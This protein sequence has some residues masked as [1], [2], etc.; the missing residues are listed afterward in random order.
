M[1]AGEHVIFISHTTDDQAIAAAIRNLFDSVFENRVVTHYSNAREGEGGVPAG[2]DW[3]NWIAEQ[4]HQCD[5]ALVILS[6]ASL[7]KPWVLWEAGAVYGSARAAGDERRVVPLS[8]R[9]RKDNL[10]GPFAHIETKNGESKEEIDA[11]VSDLILKFVENKGMRSAHRRLDAALDGYTEAVAK[12]LRSAPILLTEP[13]IADWLRRIDGAD[14]ADIPT[15]EQWVEI[16]FGRTGRHRDRM[17]DVR[18][19]RRLGELYLAQKEY[20]SAV[21]QLGLA[22][23]ASPRDLFVLRRLGHALLELADR[24]T[25]ASRDQRLAEVEALIRDIKGFDPDAMK[26]NVECAALEARYHRSTDDW[27][28]AR[29]ILESAR[30]NNRS[31]NYLSALLAQ[32]YL[33][34]GDTDKA[35]RLY[36]DRVREIQKAGDTS[37]WSLSTIAE[38]AFLVADDALLAKTMNQM[39][40]LNPTQEQRKTFIEGLERIRSWTRVDTDVPDFPTV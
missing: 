19:H 32:A 25:G 15:L 18:I 24:Q 31:S 35:R 33:A 16:A 22:R 6:P 28:R 27:E 1:P 12:A 13:M 20:P 37:F 2:A 4:V 9:V 29:D 40:R 23:L 17:L 10:P 8:F 11:F 21:R 7:S 14:A 26:T 39:G 5:L 38:H 3:F 34:T 30:K 36:R